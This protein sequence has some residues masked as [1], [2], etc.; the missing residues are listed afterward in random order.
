MDEKLQNTNVGSGDEK[1][2]EK[3]K[4]EKPRLIKLEDE[5]NWSK[6]GGECGSFFPL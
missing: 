6:G 4:Y 3:P 1:K 5:M 2:T